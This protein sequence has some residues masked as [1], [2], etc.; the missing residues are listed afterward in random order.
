MK[1]IRSILERVLRVFSIFLAIMFRSQKWIF[2]EI[3][4][5]QASQ[6][7]LSLHYKQMLNSGTQLPS[8]NETGFRTYSQNDEDGLLL[9]IFS[10]ID[11]VSRKAVEI[12]AGTGIECNSANLII[13]HGWHGLLFDGSEEMIGT[14]RNFYARHKDTFYF[15]PKLVHAWITKD[16]VNRLI[17][18]N[19]FSGDIDLLSI[20]MDGMDY[21]IWKAI[22]CIQPRVVVVEYMNVWGPEIAVTVPYREKFVSE[23]YDYH[24]GTQYSGASLQ[25]FVKLSREKNYRLVGCNRYCFNAFFIRNGIGENILPEIPS[26]LCFFHPKAQWRVKNRPVDLLK[27]HSWVE[28]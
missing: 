15:P 5:D 13:N 23:D 1:K 19:G 21:W 12:C 27:Q 11:T 7:V 4:N 10:L 24:G 14:G 20:D 18:E 26:S 25:A 6:K 28:V 16:N 2:S 8:F 3:G 17:I 9:Y 22:D